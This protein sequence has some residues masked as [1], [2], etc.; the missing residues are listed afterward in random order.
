MSYALAI[1][2]GFVSIA[3]A[4]I[5]IAMKLDKEHVPIKILFICISM[6]T[7][8]LTLSSVALILEEEGIT[9]SSLNRLTDRAYIIMIWILIFTGI[10]F[11]IY[12]IMKTIQL[13]QL[14]KEKRYEY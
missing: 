11:F 4:L 6:L 12:F 10:Y 7:F 13:L 8:I 14:K 2:F 1:V 3:F 9:S 5:Y